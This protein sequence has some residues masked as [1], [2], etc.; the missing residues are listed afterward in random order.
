MADGLLT[1]ALAKLH[2]QEKAPVLIA[3]SADWHAGVIGLTAGRLAERYY[4]PVILAEERGEQLT[5]SCR[6]P[7][8]ELNITEVLT[9]LADDL[10]SFGGHRAAA[11]FTAKLANKDKIFTKLQALI[12]KKLEGV[13]LTPT[14]ELDLALKLGDITPALLAEVQKLAPYGAGNPE[15]V[16]LLRELPTREVTTVGATKAHLKLPLGGNLSALGWSLG[17]H[18]PELRR[19]GHAD[20]AVSVEEN[21]WNGNRTIQ[22]RIHDLRPSREFG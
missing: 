22:L 3:S 16:F 21:L 9:E 15:P 7:V 8:P 18:L 6:S 19:W 2:G 20:A 5:A 4:R 10:I 17:D 12:A 11:G 1:T 14:L 13:D